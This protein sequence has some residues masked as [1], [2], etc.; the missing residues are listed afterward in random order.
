M[1]PRYALL[2]APLALAACDT[3]SPSDP[4]DIRRAYITEIVVESVPLTMPDGSGWDGSTGAGPDV[5]V[6]LVNDNTGSPIVDTEA[7]HVS[8]VSSTSFPLRWTFGS[9]PDDYG[10]EIEFSRFDTPLAL[11]VYDF[12]PTTS[13]EYMGST[14]QFRIR[15]FI[16]SAGGPRTYVPVRSEDGLYNL[17]IRLRYTR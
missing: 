9:G 8:N 16:E 10:P 17:A 11:D 5:Y 4:D 6:E 15:D 14:E 1:S 13:D 7:G 3:G 12:D 2:L